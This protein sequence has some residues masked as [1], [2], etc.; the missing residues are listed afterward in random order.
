MNHFSFDKVETYAVHI[1]MI[2][3]QEKERPAGST[4]FLLEAEIT[5]AAKQGESSWR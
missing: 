4:K 2:W 3:Q 5:E 1:R